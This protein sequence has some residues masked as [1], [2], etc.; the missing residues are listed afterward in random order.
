MT[1]TPYLALVLATY[2]AFIVVLGTV[3]LKQA[4]ADMRAARAKPLDHS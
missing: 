2:A 4:L 1:I 3:W